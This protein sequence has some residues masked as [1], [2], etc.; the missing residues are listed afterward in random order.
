M[1]RVKLDKLAGLIEW[2]DD[3]ARTRAV[4]LVRERSSEQ[5]GR[6]G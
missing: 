1:S 6:L 3:D 5:L 2:P 4:Q